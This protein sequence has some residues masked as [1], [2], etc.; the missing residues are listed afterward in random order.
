VGF[1]GD[2]EW[3]TSKPDG[4]PKELLDVTKLADALADALRG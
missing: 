3:D 1:A 2:T 4:T